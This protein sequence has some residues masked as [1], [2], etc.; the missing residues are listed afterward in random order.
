MFFKASVSEGG[1]SPGA[2]RDG[3]PSRSVDFVYDLRG[4]R[5]GGRDNTGSK[6]KVL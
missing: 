4:K 5:Y 1:F 3:R 6:V 2:E